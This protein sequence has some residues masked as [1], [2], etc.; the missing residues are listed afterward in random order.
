MPERRYTGVDFVCR[1]QSSSKVSDVPLRVAKMGMVHAEWWDANIQPKIDRDSTRAD[2]AWN[3][4]L[5]FRATTAIAK[6]ARQDP[7]SYVVGIELPNNGFLPCAMIQLVQRYRDLRRPNL[8]AVFLWY[9]SD[10]PRSALLES[11]LVSDDMTPR[12]LGTLSLDVALTVSFNGKMNG[13]V[14]LHAAKEGGD[15][16]VNWYLGRNM[17]RV[18]RTASISGFRRNDGR[19]F[20]YDEGRALQ[21]SQELDMYRTRTAK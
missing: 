1:S 15:R 19:Y 7:A 8:D 10:A 5:I 2:A 9:L 13:R 16:L 21:A 11:R 18:S 17:E 6:F 20:V 4:P 14:G 3:W 12:L